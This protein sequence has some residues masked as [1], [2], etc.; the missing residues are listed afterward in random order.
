MPAMRFDQTHEET[1]GFRFQHGRRGRGS[2]RLHWTAKIVRPLRDWRSPLPL[3]CLACNR[4]ILIDLSVAS[5]SS[6][7]LHSPMSKPAYSR[8]I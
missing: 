6:E 4:F 5:S 3:R 2:T 7:S 8:W 1:V